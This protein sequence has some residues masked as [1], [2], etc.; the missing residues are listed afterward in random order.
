MSTVIIIITFIITLLFAFINWRVMKQYDIALDAYGRV[1]CE[2]LIFVK[3][4][5]IR[6]RRDGIRSQYFPK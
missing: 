6:L 1:W 3:N 2:F 5:G 4:Q